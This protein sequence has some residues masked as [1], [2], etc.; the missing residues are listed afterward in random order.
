M[1]RGMPAE[2]RIDLENR[3]VWSKATGLLVYAD[4]T[5]HMNRLAKD[6]QFDPSFTQLLDFRGISSFDV[7]TEEIISLT[8]IRIFSPDSKRAFVMMPGVQ[9]G[10]A[11]MYESYRVTKGDR[12]I[13]VFLDHDAALAWLDAAEPAP[14]ADAVASGAHPTS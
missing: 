14:R 3:R 10:L 13:R 4:L 2:Y 12:A 11:R 8:E 1:L 6:P 7:T 9:F 5:G